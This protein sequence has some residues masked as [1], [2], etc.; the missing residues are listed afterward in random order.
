MILVEQLLL[1]KAR[2]ASLE[3]DV[4]LLSVDEFV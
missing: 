3:G 1:D 2:I 4:I